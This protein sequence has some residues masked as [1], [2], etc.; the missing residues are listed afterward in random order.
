MLLGLIIPYF[1]LP[2]IYNDDRIDIYGSTFRASCMEIDL[3]FLLKVLSQ[4]NIVSDIYFAY[5]I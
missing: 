4:S 3:T 1:S 2:D 5:Q